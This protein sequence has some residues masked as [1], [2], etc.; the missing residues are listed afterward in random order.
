MTKETQEV[1]VND[2]DVEV[3]E[4]LATAEELESRDPTSEASDIIRKLRRENARTRVAKN[5][6]AG[7]YEK[8]LSMTA[9]YE[10][11]LAELGTQVEQLQSTAAEK[12]SS[13]TK[14]LEELSEV[15]STVVATLPEEVQA[16]VP[17]GLNALELRKWL[18]TAVPVLT[19]R[20]TKPPLG[21]EEGASKRGPQGPSLNDDEL[22]V[23][24]RLGLS[25]DDYAKHKR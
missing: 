5:Q 14:F 18:D 16:I 12:E 22:I 4:L 1:Q 24:Q 21:S 13:L 25:P 11:K 9:E 8:T 6:I 23:A 20:P 15:N 19:R 2:D 17:G 7:E 10:K 3:E